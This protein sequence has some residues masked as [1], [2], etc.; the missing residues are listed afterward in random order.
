MYVE[1]VEKQKNP[2]YSGGL[3][4]KISKYYRSIAICSLLLYSDTQMFGQC[5]ISSALTRKYY[6]KSCSTES[7]ISGSGQRVSFVDPFFDAV[8]ANEY[9][10]ALQIQFLSKYTWLKDYEYEDDYSYAMFMHN[11][12]SFEKAD[13][14]KLYAFIKKFEAA[15]EGNEDSRLNI[16]KSLYQKNQAQFDDAFLQLLNNHEEFYNYHARPERLSALSL[17]HHFEPNRWIFIEG[18]AILRI[19]ERLGLSTEDEYKFCPKTAREVDPSQFDKNYFPFK[20]VL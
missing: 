12:I 7:R 13:Q 2:A 1:A 9:N 3:C 17:E 8:A 10:L 11:I 18:L 15:I 14:K 19:A 6:L 5:L 20:E 16:C 4:N